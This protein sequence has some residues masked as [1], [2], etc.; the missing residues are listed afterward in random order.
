[1]DIGMAILMIGASVLLP[2]IWVFSFTAKKLGL[3]IG[4][5]GPMGMLSRG[6]GEGEEVKKLDK[7]PLTNPQENPQANSNA[8][9]SQGQQIP[10]MGGIDNVNNLSNVANMAQDAVRT[11]TGV[12]SGVGASVNVGLANIVGAVVQNGD[13]KN[14]FRARKQLMGNIKQC[15]SLLSNSRLHGAKGLAQNAANDILNMTSNVNTMNQGPQARNMIARGRVNM[16]QSGISTNLVNGNIRSIKAGANNIHTN[17]LKMRPISRVQNLNVQSFHAKKGLALMYG[18]MANG[19]P[20]EGVPQLGNGSAGGNVQVNYNDLNVIRN[21]NLRMTQQQIYTPKNGENYDN[22]LRKKFDADPKNQNLTAEEKTRVYNIS[23]YLERRTV[24]MPINQYAEM[25]NR[26]ERIMDGVRMAVK[27]VPGATERDLL[28][29]S[30]NAFERSRQRDEGRKM[31][32]AQQANTGMNYSNEE[33]REK[34]N[35]IIKGTEA[36]NIRMEDWVNKNFSDQI[37]GISD[38]RKQEIRKQAEEY[39]LKSRSI[40][41]EDREAMHAKETGEEFNSADYYGNISEEQSKESIIQ[42]KVEE[43]TN[44]EIENNR[45][46]IIEAIKDQFIENP[47]DFRA[48]LGDEFVDKYKTALNGSDEEFKQRYVEELTKIDVKEQIDFL[49]KHPDKKGMDYYQ[50]YKARKQEE[51]NQD[52]LQAAGE[53]Y[54]QGGSVEQYQQTLTANL[55]QPEVNSSNIY[56]NRYAQERLANGGNG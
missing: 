14:T 9:M 12:Q 15:A 27:V 22:E 11:Q 32:A 41:M 26:T 6:K 48:V 29:I 49:K 1:M 36:A 51:F 40:S 55:P 38:E 3:N 23:R 20:A 54:S 21:S 52:I 37:H 18:R 25:K 44:E 43:L 30:Q 39:E 7:P 33:K 2:F 5:N 47:D 24:G 42:Q 4:F 50:V 34:L 31:L 10:Y 28:R 8:N 53:L 56:I 45:Q 46:S 35:D 19:L 16:N 17:H 13:V